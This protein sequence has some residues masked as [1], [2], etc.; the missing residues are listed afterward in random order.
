MELCYN[1]IRFCI[2][3]GVLV[4]LFYHSDNSVIESLFDLKEAILKIYATGT[5]QEEVVGK[6]GLQEKGRPIRTYVK[7]SCQDGKAGVTVVENDV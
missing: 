3:E 5:K 4:K 2:K 6:M 1:M 7:V